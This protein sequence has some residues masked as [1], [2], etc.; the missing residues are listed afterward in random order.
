MDPFQFT[1]VSSWQEKPHRLLQPSSH[2]HKKHSFKNY[3]LKGCL[4]NRKNK[5]IALL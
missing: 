2:T 4:G 3:S 5:S 1:K